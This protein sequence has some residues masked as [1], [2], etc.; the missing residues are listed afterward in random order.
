LVLNQA[1]VWRSPN[2]RRNPASMKLA[3]FFV[4]PDLSLEGRW[5]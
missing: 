1:R 4:R 3:G 5:Y 2:K